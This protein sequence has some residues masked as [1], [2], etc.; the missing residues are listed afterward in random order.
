MKKIFKNI[1]NILT[2]IRLLLIFVY[3]FIFYSFYEHTLLYALGIFLLSGLTDILDG[4]IARKYNLVTELGTLL[5]PLADKLMLITV[6]FT[7]FSI[8]IIPL[9]I[10]IIVLAKE[11]TMIIGAFL[12]YRKYDK[13]ISADY[14]GKI[15]TV[16]F[17]IAV[18]CIII[19]IPY[20]IYLLFI[21][22]A[23]NFVA[24]TNYVFKYRKVKKD[25]S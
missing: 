3:I 1:P 5:D 25:K 2:F 18:T 4:R 9:F 6:L 21:A 8:N 23:F 11:L 13:T 16:L 22:I 10:V 17:Y 24:F 7:L 19:K 12:L 15:A 20:S 14:Y